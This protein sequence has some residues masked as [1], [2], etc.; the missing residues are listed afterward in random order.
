MHSVIQHCVSQRAAAGWYINCNNVHDARIN[1]KEILIV[2]SERTGIHK[3][4]AI[5]SQAWRGPEGSWRLSLPDFMTVGTQKLLRRQPSARATF[6]P[7]KIL[8]VL[9]FVRGWVDTR[10]IV[11]PE[12][13]CKWKIQTTPSGMETAIFR[14]VA[15]CLNELPHHMR[16]GYISSENTNS[17][18]GRNTA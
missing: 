2:Y 15:Q 8:L 4:Q 11:R 14:I 18:N 3:S 12:G 17:E 7:H 13:L 10:A 6:T 9:I 1:T 16:N 5:L